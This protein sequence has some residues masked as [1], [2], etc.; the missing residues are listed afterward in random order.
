MPRGGR[1]GSHLLCVGRPV[2]DVKTTARELIRAKSYD[3][4]ELVSHILRTTHQPME[5]EDILRAFGCV[6]VCVCRG[7]GDIICCNNS[8]LRAYTELIVRS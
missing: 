7:R 2:C 4:P 3:L 1:S 6:C 5:Q 8:C